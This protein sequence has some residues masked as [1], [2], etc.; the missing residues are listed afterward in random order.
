[1]AKRAKIRSTKNNKKEK[2]NNFD[3][4]KRERER[5]LTI[6]DINSPPI[7]QKIEKNKY[8]ITIERKKEN[9]KK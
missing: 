1:M 5:E 6:L 8:I 3:P 9:N 2:K 4:R 7:K